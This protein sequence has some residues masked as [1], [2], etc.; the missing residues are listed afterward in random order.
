MN[1]RTMQISEFKTHCIEVV[2]QV[3]RD[4]APVILTL[5]GV[6]IAHVTP[7]TRARTLGSMREECV[8]HGDLVHGDFAEEWELNA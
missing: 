5:R 8:V 1:T 3:D 7:V 6:P 4:R 2:R